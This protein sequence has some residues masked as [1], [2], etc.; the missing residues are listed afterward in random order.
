MPDSIVGPII[1]NFVFMSGAD[2]PPEAARK[3]E[4]ELRRC[5]D[6]GVASFNPSNI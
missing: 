1:R 2:I 5:P 3:A 4:A 6:H